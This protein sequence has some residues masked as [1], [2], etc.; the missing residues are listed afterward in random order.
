MDRG[1]KKEIPAGEYF[2]VWE[3]FSM[4]KLVAE[5][6]KALIESFDF[7][8]GTLVGNNL[9]RNNIKVNCSAG[10]ITLQVIYQGASDIDDDAQDVCKVDAENVILVPL[11]SIL[12]TNQSN[13][14]EDE[15]KD[16]AAS[17]QQR[18]NKG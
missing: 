16:K 18:G 6:A 10:V 9:W 14:I 8:P 1:G 3:T 2:Y 15:E 4:D 17:V 7:A 11:A 12:A 13:L 5:R